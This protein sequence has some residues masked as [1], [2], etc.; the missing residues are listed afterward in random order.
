[1]T[2][3]EQGFAPALPQRPL[4]HTI[5][6]TRS[7][8]RC[9]PFALRCQLDACSSCLRQVNSHIPLSV[10]FFG[11]RSY[12]WFRIQRLHLDE[13]RYKL[14]TITPRLAPRPPLLVRL[15]PLPPALDF[16][17]LCLP[18]LMTA[19]HLFLSAYWGTRDLHQDLSSFMKNATDISFITATTFAISVFLTLLP[20][21]P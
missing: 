10:A 12:L 13:R 11:S 21:A 14:S 19:S 18:L 8:L 7:V 2:R 20:Q 17:L 15:L 9:L 4:A 6:D 16:G 1:M 5:V 3:Y